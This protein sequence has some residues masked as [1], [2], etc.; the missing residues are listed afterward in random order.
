MFFQRG[1]KRIL[2]VIA[3]VIAIVLFVAAIRPRLQLRRTAIIT[4]K[5]QLVP[6][7]SDA[8][9]PAVSLAELS[10]GS[11]V[12]ILSKDS[13]NDC[14]QIKSDKITGWIPCRN[15]LFFHSP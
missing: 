5:T 1:F 12:R 15:A 13:I 9:S 14:I 6:I 11:I 8:A 7:P 2:L 3:A 4:V 10:E